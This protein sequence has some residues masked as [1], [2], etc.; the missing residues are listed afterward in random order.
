MSERGLI[1]TNE[2]L[3][4]RV[5]VIYEADAIATGKGAYLLRTLLSEGVLRY[6]VVERTREGSKRG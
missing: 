3:S 6:E 1:Y 5:L 2:D 4:H